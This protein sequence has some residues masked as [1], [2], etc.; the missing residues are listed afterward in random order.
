VSGDQADRDAALRQEIAARRDAYAA[1][2]DQTIINIAIGSEQAPSPGPSRSV[3]GNVPARNPGFTGREALLAAVREMLLAGDR[4]VV[5]ALHGMGGV[6]K[7]QLAVEYAHRF[8]DSYDLVWWITAEQP[9][10][11]GD[12]FM[13]LAEGLD[14][15]ERESVLTEAAR[16]AVLSELRR[17]DRWLLVFDNAED[18]EPLAAWL[19]GG[20]GHVLITS[21][22]R[23]WAEVAVPVEVD[24]LVRSEAVVIL[25]DRVPWLTEADANQVA[26]AM[27]DLPL[28]VVQ[29]AGYMADTGT[30]AEVYLSL[31]KTRAG[32]VM[33]QGRPSSYP[34]SLAAVT[35][36]AFDRLAAEDPA[37]AD[38]VAACAFLAPEPV[39]ATWFSRAAT[40]LPA[41]L[42]RAAADLAAWRGVLGRIGGRALARIDHRGLQMHR[43]TQAI[44]RDRLEPEQA[45]TTRAWAEVILVAS[46]PGE[47]DNPSSWPRWA[48][49]MPHLLVADLAATD[50]PGL[51]WL[52]CSASRYLLA[53]GNARGSH[54]LASHLHEQWCER[55]GGDYPQTL[56]IAYYL[57][58][59]LRDMGR[60]AEALDF[61]QDTLV[62]CRRILGDAHPNTLGSATSVAL[63]LY[64]LGDFQAARY[65]G[66]DTLA[67]KRSV[68]GGDHPSTLASANNLALALRALSDFEAARDVDQD[69][70]ARRR[71]VLGEDHPDTLTSAS[72]LALDLRALGDAQAA[73]DLDEDILAR[74]RR[75]LG[76]DHP[77]TLASANNLAEDLRALGEAQAARDLDED[78]LAR[79][80]RVLGEDHPE[81]LRSADNLAK[82]LRALGET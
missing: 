66:Q 4:T 5:Q 60:F 2:R 75:V 72:G 58:Q 61:D 21:R 29:A 79:R 74:R 48:Q 81:T 35:Q 17:R 82:D 46:Q 41:P 37:A 14:V 57:A 7:T 6:G 3:W 23:R 19:P 80:R 64:R 47:E 36:L 16:Q 27:G 11:I 55:L 67:R 50:N 45:A 12:Q 24:V 43:L 62:R 39:P 52:A 22:T 53:R 9:G 49:L 28:G 30:P 73:R 42:S 78:I 71:R 76:E 63:D 32:K 77:D 70:L 33:D 15:V 18:P 26:E 54:D 65:L 38:A 68:L 34:Q 25:R 31:L 1:G 10:L 69:T 40:E 44:L 59:A 20:N 51:R 13:A 56:A 8:A